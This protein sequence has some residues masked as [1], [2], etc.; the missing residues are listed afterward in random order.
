M[1]NVTT[2]TTN[3]NNQ[4]FKAPQ[5]IHPKPP[6]RQAPSKS[7]KSS[8]SPIVNPIKGKPLP[9]AASRKNKPQ[10]SGQ[11]S[12]SRYDSSLGL[13]TRKFTSL[14]QAS[15]SGAIDLNEAATQLGVQKRRIYD[16]TNVLEGVGLI[17]KR[18]KNVIA[19][20]GSEPA[21]VTSSTGG[22]GVGKKGGVTEELEAMRQEVG[23]Y[24]EEE[25]LL[26]MWIATLQ[27][28]PHPQSDLYATPHDIWSA[29]LV[30]SATN[31]T[32]IAPG[33]SISQ[34]SN[35]K[36]PKDTCCFAIRAPAKSMLEVSHPNEG[37][38]NVST[39]QQQQQARYELLITH[40][41]MMLPTGMAGA[42]ESYSLSNDPNAQQWQ[43]EHIDNTASNNKAG[44]KRG[45]PSSKGSKLV[46]S[47]AL[48]SS[49]AL[50]SQQPNAVSSNTSIHIANKQLLPIDAKKQKQEDAIDVYLLPADIDAK[51]GRL[52]N[53]NMVSLESY[54]TELPKDG[55]EFLY[56]LYE[57]E[58]ISDL[59]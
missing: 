53:A 10:S 12:M 49:T 29:L 5:A 9:T 48:S 40:P 32:P 19:W 4:D 43:T 24:Y 56:S 58:G 59:F 33:T 50:P 11:P 31:D 51:D 46:D 14:I 54:Q 30:N 36:N 16:I 17:E 1:S 37:L 27:S 42:P 8:S 38:H 41:S 22:N 23:T 57:N 26:D 6:C 18:S 34:P 55:D 25:S 7:S 28:M 21:S 47:Y 20:K 15:I 52:T 39:C 44:K 13:L 45:R 2:T 35:A 3:C